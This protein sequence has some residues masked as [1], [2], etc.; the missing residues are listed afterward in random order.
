MP[1]VI[2]AENLLLGR[3]ASIVARRALRG[4]ELAIVN[5]EKAVISGKKET[6]FARYHRKYHM[7]SREKGPFFPRR[8]DRIAKRTIRG[9]LP[10]KRKIGREALARVK[11]FV[12]FPQEFAGMEIESLPEAHMNRLKSPHYVTLGAVSA[13]LGARF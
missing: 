9:M 11:I 3:M 5:V 2:N 12:G 13:H 7:G 1:R 4:E 10:Y 6:V 8:P